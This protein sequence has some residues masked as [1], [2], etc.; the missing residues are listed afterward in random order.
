MS[1]HRAKRPF[2]GAAS[3]PAQRQI[4]SF[5]SATSSPS[6]SDDDNISGGGR[7]SQHATAPALPASIQ[8]S[9]LN[10]GMRVRKSVPEGYKTGSYGSFAL[11][12]DKPA[13]QVAS[14]TDVNPMPAAKPTYSGGNRELLPFCGIHSVG[15]M[16]SQPAFA[17]GASFVSDLD[18]LPGLSSSQESVESNDSLGATVVNSRKRVFGDE[19][20]D[21]G[22]SPE[23]LGLRLF[24]QQFRHDGEVSPRSQTPVGFGN[25]RVMAVPRTRRQAGAD[26]KNGAF[27]QGQENVMVAKSDDFPEAEFLEYTSD[28]EMDVAQD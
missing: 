22:E 11:W 25:P 4:T 9:L 28:L 17:P 24:R 8:S 12:S 16:S 23:Q 1:V 21:E 14:T 19:L 18:D 10:V 20:A 7:F 2:T 27:F 5:F 15:G 13:K 6:L 3:D 26:V